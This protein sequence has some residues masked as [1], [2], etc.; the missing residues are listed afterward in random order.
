VGETTP[1]RQVCRQRL[2]LRDRHAAMLTRLYQCA[3]KRARNPRR[4]RSACSSEPDVYTRSP[5]L[6]SRS[7]S[8]VVFVVFVVGRVFAIWKSDWYYRSGYPLFH[9]PFRHPD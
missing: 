8:F 5:P 4:P 7:C 9:A 3:A 6:S 2:N 1:V